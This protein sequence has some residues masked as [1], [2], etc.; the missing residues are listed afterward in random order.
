MKVFAQTTDAK[1]DELKFDQENPTVGDLRQALHVTRN[2]PVE[3][4][5]MVFCGQ[6]LLDDAKTLSSHKITDGSKVI[7]VLKKP[8]AVP[9]PIVQPVV[10]PT[11]QPSVQSVQQVQQQVLNQVDGMIAALSGSL[12]NDLNRMTEEERN[13]LM[14]EFNGS[15]EGQE[16]ARLMQNPEFA[17]MADNV[18]FMGSFPTTDYLSQDVARFGLTQEHKADLEELI[19]AGFGSYQDI[20]QYY[21]A[22]GYDKNAT[23]NALLDGGFN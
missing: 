23:V 16:L 18:G 20:L 12:Q 19:E 4:I 8:K 11:V 14:T 6:Q 3:L 22:F 2:H 17:N 13:D 21:V 5:L 15:P 9:Q 1:C 10:Q 7:I